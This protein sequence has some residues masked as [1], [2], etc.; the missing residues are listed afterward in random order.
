MPPAHL[1]IVCCHGIWLGGPQN[2]LDESEWLIA[3]FQAGETPTFIEHI[4]AGLRALSGDEDGILMFSG[5]PTRKETRISEASSYANLAAANSY[6]GIL[7]QPSESERVVEETRA[8]DSYYNVL[9]SLT[10]FW[11]DYSNWPQRVTIV[12]HAFKRERLVDC[13]CGAIGYPLDRVDFIGVDP[14]GMLDGSNEAAIKGV[15]QAVTEWKEDPHGTGV[16]LAAKRSKRNPW[17]IAQ[18][19]FSA[20]EVRER[21]GVQT[22]LLDGIEV[23]DPTAKQPWST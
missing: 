14:P 12:S 18:G 19:L 8:L 6:F 7:T 1:I 3:P 13:H 10:K 22:K 4:K 9:F 21:S 17:G 23:L 20:G 5:G 16:S 11:E 2:G 15:V